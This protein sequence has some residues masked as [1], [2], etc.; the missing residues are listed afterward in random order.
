[1]KCSIK[2]RYITSLVVACLLC[3]TIITFSAAAA[4]TDAVAS[5]AK[6]AAIK[7]AEN[8]RGI[9]VDIAKSLW[10]YAEIGLDEYKSYVKARD[11]LAGAGFAIKQSAAGHSHLPRG[12]LRF[13][14]ASPG[15]I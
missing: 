3:M 2:G 14:P 1:M 15:H 11:V 9:T 5:S 4:V 7:F 13:G 10:E 12:H 6:A 8:N